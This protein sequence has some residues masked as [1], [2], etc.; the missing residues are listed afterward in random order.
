MMNLLVASRIWFCAGEGGVGEFAEGV[1][2]D[3]AS[4]LIPKSASATAG[5]IS[6]GIK[7]GLRNRFG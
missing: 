4:R 5:D 7:S 6:R 2:I 3:E 1:D